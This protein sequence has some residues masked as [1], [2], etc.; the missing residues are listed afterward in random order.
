[1]Q[2][3]KEPLPTPTSQVTPWAW[4]EN[5]VWPEGG[6]LLIYLLV[7]LMAGLAS[8]LLGIG[9]GVLI[10]PILTGFLRV[11]LRRAI[12][13]SIVTVLGVVTVGVVSE[14][15][16]TRNIQWVLAVFLAVGAQTG[17]WIGGRVGPKIPERL[18]RYAFMLILLFTAAK[19]ANLLPV[20]PSFGLFPREALWSAWVLSVLLLGMLAGFLSVLLG[21]GGGV[22]VVPG[23]L[24]LIEGIGFRAA[25]ATSLAMIIP[26][27]LTGTLVHLW[28]KNVLWRSV[29]SLVIPGFLGAVTGV[30]LANTVPSI[31]LRQLVFPIFLCIMIVRLGITNRIQKVSARN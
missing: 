13:I 20:G 15:L 31:W 22:V 6:I 1:M 2:T 30:V 8:A 26:T 16:T 3:V 14:A 11:P 12:G 24:F 25:R 18:L 23:L 21:I 19:L 27:A 10:V 5:D 17:V 9:A 29:L 28:Q 7:G 4:T